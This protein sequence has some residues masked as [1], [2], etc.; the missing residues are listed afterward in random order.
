MT[1]KKIYQ[2]PAIEL[3]EAETEQLLAQSV[4]SVVSTGLDDDENLN[5]S[6]ETGN[7]GDAMVRRGSYN[8]WDEAW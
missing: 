3:C 8:V 4:E 6:G 2:R 1:K 7:A 5:Y